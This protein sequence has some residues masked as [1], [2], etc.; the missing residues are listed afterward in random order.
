MRGYIINE[1]DRD[2]IYRLLEEPAQQTID[3]MLL[4][5]EFESGNLSGVQLKYIESGDLLELEL[6]PIFKKKINGLE[7]TRVQNPRRKEIQDKLNRT[8]ASK[9][10]VRLIN[11]N[12]D[13]GD[14]LAH[15]GYDEQ[16]LPA[17]S[18]GA[19]KFFSRYIDRLRRWAQKNKLKLKYIYVTEIGLETGRIHHHIICNVPREVCEEKWDGGKYPT[20]KRAEP[21][22]FELT[23]F[24]T[25]ISGDKNIDPDTGAKKWERDKYEKS[26]VCSQNLAKPIIRTANTKISPR[27]AEKLAWA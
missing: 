13:R 10:V 11:T 16:H 25:Y 22:D 7:M 3:G 18:H 17:D 5:R 24:A 23:G 8:N 6:Y 21:D 26:Y 15:L 2:K 20:T 14:T 19:R 9:R 12:F 1:Y 4:R 27:Q